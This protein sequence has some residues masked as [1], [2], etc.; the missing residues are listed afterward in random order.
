MADIGAAVGMA[1]AAGVV[2]MVGA[3]VVGTVVAEGMVAITKL[4]H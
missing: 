1:A 3:A 2:G 4:R